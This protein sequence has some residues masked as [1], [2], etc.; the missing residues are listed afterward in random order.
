MDW[1]DSQC[2]LFL[3]NIARELVIPTVVERFRSASFLGKSP[4]LELVQFLIFCISFEYGARA[5][6]SN[7]RRAAL[8]G[9]VSG[10]SPP[11]KL[12]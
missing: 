2:F 5:C 12:V 11:L 10:K 4:P 1:C 6:D 9:L 8:I 3:L 7:G